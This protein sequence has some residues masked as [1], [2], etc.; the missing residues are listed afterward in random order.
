MKTKTYLQLFLAIVAISLVSCDKDQPNNLNQSDQ[1]QLTAGDQ[2]VTNRILKF[3]QK[4]AYKKAHPTYK[5]GELVNVDSARWDVET[6]FNATYAF[7]DENYT[8][9]RQDSAVLVLTIINDSTTL[10]DDVLSFNDLVFDQVLTLYNNSPLV[11]R[12]LLFVSL[13]NGEMSNGELEVKLMVVTGEKQTNTYNFTPFA[14]GDNW[15]YGSY[16]GKCDGTFSGE[17]DAAKELQNLLNLNKTSYCND[18]PGPP[19]LYR[20]IYSDDPMS[21]YGLE[22]YE[23]RNENTGEYPMF[24]IEKNTPLTDDD[25]CLNYNEMNLHY[26]G[27]WAV[28]YDS[29][30]IEFNRPC[31]WDFML[32]DIQGKREEF[33]SNPTTYRARHYNDLYYSY[34]HWVR[35]DCIPDPISLCA[36]K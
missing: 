27:E 21:P 10:M 19:S 24:Y 2:F 34:H 5:S 31:N 12:E 16:L 26:N 33:G 15:M 23:F 9:T 18:M 14:V 3:R 8:T 4:L 25:L 30:R 36:K 35:R 17:S 11:N 7:P 32:C 22:G 1:Y 6:N 20:K 13:R 28:I 29:M